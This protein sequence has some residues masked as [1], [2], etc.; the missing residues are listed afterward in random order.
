MAP[1]APKPINLIIEFFNLRDKCPICGSFLQ[2][3]LHVSFRSATG[4][5]RYASNPI[6]V[7]EYK[8]FTFIREFAP[9]RAIT[10]Y[11]V[12]DDMG[13]PHLIQLLEQSP[14]SIHFIKFYKAYSF[15]PKN[16]Y[17]LWATSPTFEPDEEQFITSEYRIIITAD[18]I[19]ETVYDL[20]VPTDRNYVLTCTPEQIADKVKKLLLIQ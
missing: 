1:Q 6:H 20:V 13:S 18:E 8:S 5:M 17:Y 14:P 9:N 15:C 2:R 12:T 10:D 19:E 11:C 4:T 16:E 3:K 7:E